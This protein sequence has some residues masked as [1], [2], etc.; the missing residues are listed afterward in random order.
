MRPSNPARW[1]LRAVGLAQDAYPVAAIAASDDHRVVCAWDPP[2]LVFVT[3]TR[4]K[5]HGALHRLPMGVGPSH[6]AEQFDDELPKPEGWM[7]QQTTPPAA[8]AALE[9]TGVGGVTADGA[10]VR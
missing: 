3:H 7:K 9:D 1:V 2:Y 10:L 5:V 8:P 6:F 4:S